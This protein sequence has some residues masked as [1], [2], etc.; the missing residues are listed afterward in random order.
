MPPF[1]S[2]PFGDFLRSTASSIAR[3]T[4]QTASALEGY[5]SADV[6]FTRSSW[7]NAERGNRAHRRA[8][9]SK[10]GQPFRRIIRFQ[11]FGPLYRPAQSGERLPNGAPK[12]EVFHEHRVFH[13][14]KGM[15]VYTGPVPN[16]RA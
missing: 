3:A 4:R 12:L 2:S 5:A 7:T 9:G 10:R 1:L 16:A 11:R 8:H 6:G 15:R 14:T 13:A